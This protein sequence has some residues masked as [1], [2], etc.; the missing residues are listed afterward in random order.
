M[1]KKALI[2]MLFVL[3]ITGTMAHAQ[4]PDYIHLKYKL[5]P[6]SQYY[7]SNNEDMKSDDEK[8]F[9]IALRSG[10]Q[11]Y[12]DMIIEVKTGKS[13]FKFDT[14]VVEKVKGKEEYWTDPEN[15]HY[16]ST[17]DEKGNYI[18]KE[19]VFN[20][21]FYTKGNNKSIDWEITDETKNILGFN[22]MKAVSKNKNL[23]ITVWFTKEIPLNNG[24]SNFTGLPGLV[25]WA[26]DFFNTFTTEKISYSNDKSS[27]E[28]EYNNII[29]KY[30]KEKKSEIDDKTFLLMKSKI[31]KQLSR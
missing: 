26:E 3:S 18:K 20:Q 14:L 12:F 9:Q 23:L 28:K 6:I 31:A 10:Y 30:D 1:K 27:F 8:S 15:K 25:L 4:T 19:S 24:P 13:V 7:F 29:N 16:F 5:V 21:T 22:C 17:K 2:F 11:Y